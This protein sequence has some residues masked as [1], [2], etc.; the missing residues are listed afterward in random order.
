[1]YYIWVIRINKKCVCFYLNLNYLK[2][3][4]IIIKMIYYENLI[5]SIYGY[6]CSMYKKKLGNRFY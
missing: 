3:I 2:G 4:F 1:M 6:S 5:M